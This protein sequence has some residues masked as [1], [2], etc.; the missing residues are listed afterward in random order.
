MRKLMAAAALSLAAIP[1]LL[2]ADGELARFSVV[3]INPASVSIIIGTVSMTFPPFV[4][5]NSVY[6]STYAAKVFPF[7]YSEKGRI[8][9]MVPDEDLSRVSRGES[10]DFKGRAVNDSGD[11]RRIEGRVTPTGPRQGKI[12]VR[13]FVTRRISLT[14]DTTY[15]LRG[16]EGPRAAVIPR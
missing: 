12:R 8:W 15:E 10:V 3:A 1:A 16:A 14:Y 6:S 9:I 2:G 4:R 7:F 13:V 11:D 5:R